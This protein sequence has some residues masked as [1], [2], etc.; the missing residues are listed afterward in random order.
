MEILGAAKLL[1]QVSGLGMITSLVLVR[2]TKNLNI[3]N[4][5][6][7]KEFARRCGVKYYSF[8]PDLPPEVTICGYDLFKLTKGNLKVVYNYE[9]KKDKKKIFFCEILP[10]LL[11]ELINFFLV[12]LLVILVLDGTISTIFV[13]ISLF[14]E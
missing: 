8:D 5:E 12:S 14:F 7:W 11:I 9:L 1:S 13:V 6:F 3:Y 4:S 10:F 2:N